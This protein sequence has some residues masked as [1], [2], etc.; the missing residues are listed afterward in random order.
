MFGENGEVNI[1]NKVDS[2]GGDME[3]LVL[4]LSDIHFDK[5]N[6][7]RDKNIDSILG[8]IRTLNTFDSVLIVISGDIA[9]SGTAGQ[10]NI[11]FDFYK[12]LMTGIKE[13]FDIGDVRLFIVPGNHDVNYTNG[14]I[15]HDELVEIFSEK[16][17]NSRMI[18]ESKKMSSFYNHANGIKCFQDKGRRISV[19]KVEY[20]DFDIRLNLVNS[21]IF[22][23]RE[24]DLGY[25]YLDNDDLDMLEELSDEDYVFTVMHHPY[26]W[27]ND[28][29]MKR[30]EIAL[31]SNSDIVFVG[32]EH[33]SAALDIRSRNAEVKIFAGGE[34]SNRGDWSNSV[35]FAGILNSDT[36]K[37][38]QNKFYWDENQGIYLAQ[39]ADP[40]TLKKNRKN[41]YGVYL[42]P[43]YKRE[44][45]S[46]KKY[47]ITDD[48]SSYYVFP[49]LEEENYTDR[50]I[51]K[52][53]SEMDALLD[54]V[55]RHKR[56]SIYGRK[57]S[58]KTVLLK[59]IFKSV[60]DE[61][62]TI[63]VN[64]E[65]IINNRFERVL[66]NS[67]EDMYTDDS[68]SY[69]QYKQLEKS[70]KVLFVDDMD[71]IDESLFTEF[72]DFIE[73]EYEF[74]VYSCG[75]VVELDMRERLKRGNRTSEYINYR[76]QAFYKDKRRELVENIV[77][78]LVVN[79]NSHVEIINTL[80]SQLSKQKNLFRMEPDFI[81]QFTKYYCTNIGET[82]QSDG[83]VFSKVFEANIVSLIKPNA[84]RMS[85]DK[86]L[87][88]LDK[89]A[90]EMHSTRTTPLCQKAIN[91]IISEYNDEFDSVVDYE[92]F[93]KI[94]KDSRILVKEE[95]CYYFAEKNYLA[96]FVAREIKRKCLEEQDFS[97]FNKALDYACFGINSDILLFVTYITDN[98]NLIRMLIDKGFEYTSDWSSFDLNNITIPYLSDMNQL[99]VERLKESDKKESEKRDIDHEKYLEKTKNRSAAVVYTYEEK[100]LSIM[101][102]MIRAVSLLLIISRTLPSFE[103][104]MRKK[105]KE[106]CV[107]LIYDLP[108]RIF[109]I[110]AQGIEDNKLELIEL[111]K[112]NHENAYMG[113]NPISDVD[114]LNRIRWES[115]SVLLEMMNMSISNA[116]K[117]NTYRFIDSFDYKRSFAYQIEHL[118]GLDSRDNV[119]AFSSEAEE[120]FSSSKQQLPKLMVQRVAKHYMIS[121]KKIKWNDIQRLNSKLWDGKLNNVSLLL[122]KKRNESKEN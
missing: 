83:E 89:I 61:K 120:L 114:A 39:K 24:D 32:H 78:V 63:F 11:A 8:A 19:T 103:H 54:D 27:F 93:L 116:T 94:V 51:G 117:Q 1:L 35:F 15:T 44:F 9:F 23:T 29:M 105:D 66:R 46:D 81:I 76:I 58:G 77:Q 95:S 38:I 70:N 55:Y 60:Y 88:V 34:L 56:I 96:Y 12:K 108:L 3:L 41:K 82:M 115:I 16:K 17:Q 21:A 92:E 45:F 20:L 18:Q 99:K 50:R 100:E 31:Y 119:K 53:I 2:E 28:V 4:H 65:D 118:M 48:F 75:K 109:N 98:I 6:D 49:R 111:F 84:G 68:L 40:I 102:M 52:E 113:E 73:N 121:S 112:E 101:E 26:Y 72:L 22:S 69:E 91:R 90:F 57:D 64:G 80:C 122:N 107:N 86:I 13:C 85:V 74:I 106:K 30:L 36:R 79:K 42:K 104:M 67:Y 62:C 47:M 5:K 14:M 10:Y 59:Q 37:Y 71:D 110:W 43:A 7:F 97:E 87:I 33:Y 25:H